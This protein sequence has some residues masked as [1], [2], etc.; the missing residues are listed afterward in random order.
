[1]WIFDGCEDLPF[2]KVLLNGQRLIAGENFK[3]DRARNSGCNGVNATL[4]RVD[5][6]RF[7]TLIVLPD[8]VIAG[9]GGGSDKRMSCGGTPVDG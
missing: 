4:E 3:C 5:T 7:S 1:M 8:Q 6:P 9:A 2:G